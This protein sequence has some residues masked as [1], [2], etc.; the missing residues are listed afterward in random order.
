[1]RTGMKSS[2]SRRIRRRGLQHG[3]CRALL[4]RTLT[5]GGA[6]Y[7]ASRLEAATTASG[8]AMRSVGSRRFDVHRRDSERCTGADAVQLTGCPRC[9]L[10]GTSSVSPCRGGWGS[11]VDSL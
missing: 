8:P 4:G 10:H 11:R 5:G 6:R 1:V 7:G 3:A 9:L 2:G